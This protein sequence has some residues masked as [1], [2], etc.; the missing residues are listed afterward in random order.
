MSESLPR[1]RELWES[2]SFQLERLQASLPCVEEEEAGL[3]SRTAPCYKLTFDPE[4]TPSA[5]EL[6]EQHPGRVCNDDAHYLF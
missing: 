3:A 4:Q 1:L 5:K 2:T 6:G